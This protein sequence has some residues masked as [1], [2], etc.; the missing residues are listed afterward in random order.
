MEQEWN[1]SNV[2]VCCGA[3][4]IGAAVGITIK[5]AFLACDGR[6]QPAALDART[7]YLALS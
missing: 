7:T 6:N 3:H 4:I 5:D 2:G 1:G